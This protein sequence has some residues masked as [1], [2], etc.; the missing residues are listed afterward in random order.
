MRRIH[1]NVEFVKVLAEIP[2]G[3]ESPQYMSKRDDYLAELIGQAIAPTY[4]CHRI[5]SW[6]MVNK[7]KRFLSYMSMTCLAYGLALLLDK[8]EYWGRVVDLEESLTPEEKGKYKQFKK[9][10][11]SVSED[12]GRRFKWKSKTSSR[13]ER[14]G[15]WDLE[16]TG[17]A[18]KG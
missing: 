4:G 3:D 13:P 18:T 14:E 15:R 6:C 1:G 8:H 17:S 5:K 12:F 16:G 2:R 9:N 10:K 7:G 11:K